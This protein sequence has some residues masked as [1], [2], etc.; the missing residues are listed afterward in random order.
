MVRIH[1]VERSNQ[2]QKATNWGN[3]THPRQALGVT[4]RCTQCQKN[5]EHGR[6]NLTN[7]FDVQNDYQWLMVNG[8][9]AI[10]DN[11]EYEQPLLK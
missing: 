2:S 3:E 6:A 1:K 11:D 8:W 9:L 5:E 4:M 7:P 10:V